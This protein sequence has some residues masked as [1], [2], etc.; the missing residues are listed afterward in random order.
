[1][2]DLR[3]IPWMRFCRWLGTGAVVCMVG[4]LSSVATATETK[5]MERKV[6]KEEMP[7]IVATEPANV[8]KTFQQARGF[9]L[10]LVASEPLV[11][12]PV[13]ACFDAM[14]R[15]YVAEMHGYPFSQEPTKLNPDG[16]G[17]SNA[18]IIRVLEDTDGDGRMDHSVVFADQISWPTSVCCYRGGIFVL[19]P[20]YLYYF[21]DTDGDNRADVREVIL[22]GFGRDNVQSVTNGLQWGIDNRIYFAAGRNPKELLHREQPL[23]STN[24][25]DLKFDPM[26][27]E[28]E[29]ITGGLQFGHT[30]DDW[31]TRFVCSNSNHIQQ[32]IFRESYLARNPYY[33]APDAIRS[34]ATDGSS[35]RVFRASPPEP[36]RIIRQK[37]RAEA[38]G[39]KLVLNK[40]GRWEFRPL[41]PTLKMEGIPTEYPVGYFTSATG[42]TIYRGNAYP[43]EF[44]G[45]AFIGDVGGNLVHRKR[46]YNKDIVYRAERADVGEEFVRSSDNWFRPVN[47]V[48][49]PDGTL[50][51]LDMYRETV[52]HPYS[53]PEAIKE[54]L[55]LTSGKERGRIYRLVSPGMKRIN[56]QYP[57]KLDQEQLVR[58]LGSDNGWIRYTAQRLLWEEGDRRI[59]PLIENFLA[60]T[61]RPLGRLH[62]LYTLEGLN[63][64][65]KSHVLRGLKDSHPRVKAHAVRLAES[66]LIHSPEVL[67]SLLDLCN[68]NNEHVLFQ[69]AFTLGESRDDR[70]IR[71][72]AGMAVRVGDHPEIRSALLSSSGES[73]GR[74]ID[75][76]IR[77]GNALSKNHVPQI[78][79][80]LASMIGTY[81]ETTSAVGLLSD[82]TSPQ[83]PLALQQRLLA[84]L[85]EGLSRRGTSLSVLL[86]EDLVP[87]KF[88][89]QLTERFR[90]AARVAKDDQYPL[91]DRTAAIQFLGFADWPIAREP[92]RMFLS[93]QVLQPLQMAAVQSMAVQ[94]SDQVGDDL[95]QEWSGYSP[96]VRRSVV[97]AILSRSDRI[98]KLITA[99]ESDLI[100]PS[101]IGRD[102]KQVLMSHPQSAIRSRSR[103]LFVGEV[104]SNRAEV[105]SNFQDVLEIQGDV[106]RG[107]KVFG[108]KCAICHQVGD[109][110]YRVAPNLSSVQNKSPEDLLIA[111]LDPNREAQ[112]NFNVYTLVTGQG[113]VYTGIIATETTNSLT[114]QR[115][116]AKQDVIFRMNIDTLTSTGM[117]LMPE[118]L[119]KDLSRQD[120]ADVISFVKSI[121]IP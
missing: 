74:L 24:G 59:V 111:I 60:S 83:V 92:L 71:G 75:L 19:A 64:L 54:F 61:N 33:V 80:Q 23:F 104:N 90:H 44:R 115:A 98:Q 69:L 70:A 4:G 48:N 12:D 35:A 27:E 102:K 77:D 20:Q 50:F 15:M 47:F 46:I 36:W 21:K 53:I 5:P 1:M 67:E 88:R 120:L 3:T 16:G 89:G 40:E 63:A 17:S 101:E 78:L 10:E 96:R 28:F 121:R 57:G 32:V 43:E 72:L 94:D 6:T 117:S 76:I 42:V 26:T 93:P 112:P 29:R 62:A 106:E 41:D 108:E 52:E 22:S 11:A 103:N 99:I 95:L 84:G 100:K 105:V 18:G 58:Q 87:K 56:V 39:Y 81:P 2:V 38:K 86:E 97:D 113:R 73:A 7:R 9:Q 34:I 65:K 109:I 82:V 30:M 51:V 13:A 79:A 45:N 55:H 91:D 110:G 8:L 116:E 68:D 85:G 119:E 107:K 31:G 25:F 114:L 49:A 14:G 37:W 66:F 118:G